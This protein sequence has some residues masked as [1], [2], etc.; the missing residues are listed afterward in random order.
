[1]SP[2][3]MPEFKRVMTQLLADME[4]VV[5]RNEGNVAGQLDSLIDTV[6]H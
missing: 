3:K 2:S 6:G 4:D 1:M 5:E